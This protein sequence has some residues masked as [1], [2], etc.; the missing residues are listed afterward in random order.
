MLDLK[1]Y[2]EK[3]NFQEKRLPGELD[4]KTI[5]SVFRM[6]IQ[7][8]YGDRGRESIEPRL[9]REQRLFVGF[10]SSLWASEIWLNRKNLMEKTNSMLGI[11]AIHEI[12]VSMDA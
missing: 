9:Y 11:E 6:V 2:L 7:S 5:F 10:Q 3:K 12:K 8:E 1:Q 4:E